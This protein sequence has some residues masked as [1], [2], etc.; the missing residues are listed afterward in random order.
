MAGRSRR[1]LVVSAGTRVGGARASPVHMQSVSA[2]PGQ[3]VLASAC[4]ATHLFCPRPKSSALFPRSCWS[5]DWNAVAPFTRLPLA[6]ALCVV[7][8]LVVLEGLG[9]SRTRKLGEEP[10]GG[11][12]EPNSSALPELLRLNSFRLGICA[13]CSWTEAVYRDIEVGKREAVEGWTARGCGAGV[14]DVR[15]RSRLCSEGSGEAWQEVF[16][17]PEASGTCKWRRGCGWDRCARNPV[18]SKSAYRRPVRRA[19]VRPSAM[20]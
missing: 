2:P 8:V 16:L 17:R 13:A 10:G 14:V 18:V 15:S 1:R 6:A 4:R 20:S 5:G 12:V 19:S 3:R 7:V 11:S 9:R